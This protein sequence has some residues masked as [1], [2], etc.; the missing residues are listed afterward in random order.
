MN[1]ECERKTTNLIKQANFADS[2]VWRYT[3]FIK[4]KCQGLTL[5]YM[6]SSEVW[7][8][9]FICLFCYK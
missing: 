5:F 7:C 9:Y 8:W 4:I 3:H 6:L 2:R 1:I